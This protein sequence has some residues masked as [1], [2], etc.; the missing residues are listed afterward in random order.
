MY[1]PDAYLEQEKHRAIAW[2]LFR[3]ILVLAIGV[4]AG[5]AAALSV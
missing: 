5:I 3:A 4:L 1:D 2:R